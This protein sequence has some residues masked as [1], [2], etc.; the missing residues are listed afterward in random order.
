MPLMRNDARLVFQNWRL[1]KIL[2]AGRSIGL[3]ILLQNLDILILM[4]NVHMQ[5][6]K[7]F[8]QVMCIVRKILQVEV[9]I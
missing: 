5:P 7:V 6:N 9:P 8:L 1:T 4:K 2:W 3:N